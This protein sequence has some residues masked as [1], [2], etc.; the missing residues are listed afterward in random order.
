MEKHMKLQFLKAQ[1]GVEFKIP[2]QFLDQIRKTFPQPKHKTLAVFCA[3]QFRSQLDKVKLILEE[4]GY[5]TVT[6][7]PFRTAIEGQ[8]LGCD[9][10]KDSLKLDLSEV[11][12]FVYV[13]DGYFH[14]NALLLAQE[15]EETIKE[16]LLVNIVQ[17][18]LEVIGKDHISKYLKRKK[19]NIAKFHMSEVIGVFVTCKWGQEYKD[20]ALKLKELY[21][22]K[23]FYFFVA[24][25]FSE[26]EMENF[27]FIE[28]WIN[29]ACPRIGQDDIV[30]HTKALINIKDVWDNKH[31]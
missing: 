10:Y 18:T 12:G 23:Q 22:K 15:H 20:S 4:N 14:P 3:V 27:P 7:Q 17:Q 5:S 6:S 28:C 24:D 16:V 9:S 13:G 21:P 1:Y 11:D 26:L 31:L 2:D 25:N 30:R 29:T 8:L 19:A